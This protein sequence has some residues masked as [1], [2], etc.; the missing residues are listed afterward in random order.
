MPPPEINA[1]AYP[2]WWSSFPPMPRLPGL[3]VALGLPLVLGVAC[4]AARYDR[5]RGPEVAF[6]AHI[7]EGHGSDGGTKARGSGDAAAPEQEGGAQVLA[8]RP[9]GSL[10][11]PDPLRLARQ[12]Q[13][14]LLYDRGKVR[15]QSVK[16]LR[17]ARPVV[18]SRNM[19]RYAI[20]LWIGHELVDRVRFDFP[21]VAAEAPQHGPRRPIN[22]PPTLAAGAVATRQVL[23]PASTRATRAVLVNRASGG[24]QP[25]PWPP[26]H[27][28]PPPGL[29][30]RAPV[31]TDGGAS[32]AAS[33]S[34]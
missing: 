7:L 32:D 17:F 34:R 27:P 12:W 4:S 33:D 10:P 3:A 14:T 2:A 20:E 18:T 6:P 21:L 8:H 1:L 30:E 22:E 28:L 29:A 15:I 31:R 25:L 24:R 9:A 5:Q 13:Y 19:G 23:V 16:A 26:D 11:D